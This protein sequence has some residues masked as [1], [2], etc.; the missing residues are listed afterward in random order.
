MKSINN[1]LDFI[2]K[3]GIEDIYNDQPSAEMI[4][5]KISYELATY[6]QDDSN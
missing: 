2:S 5:D 1:F 4:I 6:F 3:L